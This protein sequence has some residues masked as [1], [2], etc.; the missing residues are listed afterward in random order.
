[1][2]FRTLAHAIVLCPADRRIDHATA[3]ARRLLAGWFGTRMVTSRSSS[4]SGCARARGGP[5]HQTQ[6]RSCV[7]DRD[8]RRIDATLRERLSG[9]NVLARRERE[10]L[11]YLGWRWPGCAERARSCSEKRTCL[12]EVGWITDNPLDGRR[13]R[14]HRDHGRRVAPAIHDLADRRDPRLLPRPGV[15]RHTH[16]SSDIPERWPTPVWSLTA[17]LAKGTMGE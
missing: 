3:E 15:R 9:D 5:V 7:D 6:G 1:M 8:D 14:Q 13:R 16:R 10:M 11:R 4:T 2:T 12:R 17:A